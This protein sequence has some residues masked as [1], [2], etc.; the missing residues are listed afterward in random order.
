[1]KRISFI[2]VSI[3]LLF[4]NFVPVQTKQNQR[5]YTPKYSSSSAVERCFEISNLDYVAD[6]KEEEVSANGDKYRYNTLNFWTAI[7]S[8]YYKS[9]DTK[10]FYILAQAKMNT[11]SSKLQ[12]GYFRMV[13]K[14]LK[15]TFDADIYVNS[16]YDNSKISMIDYTPKSYGGVSTSSTVTYS[17]GLSLDNATSSVSF[18]TDV[19]EDN[20]IL[21]PS[22]KMEN[23]VDENSDEYLCLDYKFNNTS[24]KKLTSNPPF[25]GD[26]IQSC[27]AVYEIQNYSEISSKS[28]IR[29]LIEAY[30]TTQKYSVDIF[31][32]HG[33]ETKTSYTYSAYTDL[34]I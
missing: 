9:A 14:E 24:S 15:I 30:A 3:S 20:V 22:S 25:Q 17:A 21:H 18:S 1:M 34:A 28:N 33:H 26:F 10:Y 27:V 31:G 5:N 8:K 12:N 23:D 11:N 29:F 4:T 19:Y 32:M 13:S 7:Y 6:R 16:S 2:I